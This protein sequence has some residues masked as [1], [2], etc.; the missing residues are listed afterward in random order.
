MI[1]KGLVTGINERMLTFEVENA[2]TV[3]MVLMFSQNPLQKLPSKGTTVEVE[4]ISKSVPFIKSKNDL[5]Y[6]LQIESEDGSEPAFLRLNKS[7]IKIY[8]TLKQGC[9]YKLY[10]KNKINKVFNKEISALN[11]SLPLCELSSGAIFIQTA[12]AP[13]LNHVMNVSEANQQISNSSRLISFQG[14]I[15]LKK[16]VN[17]LSSRT[18]RLSEDSAFGTPGIKTHLLEFK[19]DD[20]KSFT[21]YLNN[22]ENMVT[23]YCLIPNMRV[24]VHNVVSQKAKYYKSTPL[25]SFEVI[26]Y[27]PEAR[28]DTVN[29][30]SSD[31]GLPYFLGGRGVPFG[32]IIW[33]KSPLL[34]ILGLKIHTDPVSS[35]DEFNSKTDIKITLIANDPMGE[36]KVIAKDKTAMLLLR[37]ILG[38]QE[39]V[40]QKWYQ[41]M[42]LL[43]TYEYWKGIQES[44]DTHS[45]DKKQSTRR[46]LT[47]YFKLLEKFRF[48]LDVKCRKMD[49]EPSGKSVYFLLDV[50]KG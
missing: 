18:H 21:V 26:N 32:T 15:S 35:D 2:T 11:L 46:A 29:L 41:G 44:S 17:P 23:P 22:W 3:H 42:N 27:E 34:F 7:Y 39:P 49:E 10:F 16:F 43:G 20:G 25:T 12:T 37:L 38:A 50:R 14:K 9:K 36:S 6:W 33:A 8:P 19:T 28:F 30:C 4:I 5:E 1:I 13:R 47:R 48:G 40:F 45:M 24:I 31:W